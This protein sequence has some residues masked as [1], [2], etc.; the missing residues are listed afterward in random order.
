MSETSL[1]DEEEDFTDKVSVVSVLSLAG[2]NHLPLF[3]FQTI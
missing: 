3:L 2:D 1:L